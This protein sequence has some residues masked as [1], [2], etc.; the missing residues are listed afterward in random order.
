MMTSPS[1]WRREVRSSGHARKMAPMRKAARAHIHGNAKHGDDEHGEAGGHAGRGDEDFFEG[2]GSLTFADA[3]DEYGDGSEDG[4]N[5][6]GER[7]Y[8][9]GISQ[10]RRRSGGDDLSAL[11]GAAWRSLWFKDTARG[12]GW[13]GRPVATGVAVRCRAGA[14][15]DSVCR[16]D[17][18]VVWKYCSAACILAAMHNVSS[19]GS[20]RLEWNRVFCRNSRR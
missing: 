4:R 11:G 19:R 16:G 20:R 18:N 13:P 1:R 3:P 2:D 6:G 5:R 9:H 10:Q 14:A 7:G 12:R 17:T 15:G 8:V